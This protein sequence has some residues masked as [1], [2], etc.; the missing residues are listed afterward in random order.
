MV[1]TWKAILHGLS[2]ITLS[3]VRV[4]VSVLVS[5]MLT[6]RTPTDLEQQENRQM[7]MHR[8]LEIMDSLYIQQ[9]HIQNCNC[10]IEIVSTLRNS[11]KG[12][13]S[14]FEQCINAMGCQPY[15]LSHMEASYCSAMHYHYRM[16]H[17]PIT[18]MCMWLSPCRK[19]NS[20]LLGGLN[21]SPYV[22]ARWRPHW[23][24]CLNFMGPLRSME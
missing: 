16:I 21:S 24:P 20:H 19:G 5:T 13:G 11:K 23:I 14:H 2:W 15:W 6:L 17:H 12:I 18:I 22:T 9:V 10:N 8:S 1:S 3:G 4:T 7:F